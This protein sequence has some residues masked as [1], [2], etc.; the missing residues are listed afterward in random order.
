MQNFGAG[1]PKRF[2]HPRG[3]GIPTSVADFGKHASLLF[4]GLVCG[5]RRRGV[6]HL[7]IGGPYGSKA[8]ALACVTWHGAQGEGQTVFPRIASQPAKYTL[9][10]L[11]IY[12]DALHF[13]N[14]LA[15]QMKEVAKKLSEDEMRAVAAYLSTLN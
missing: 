10:Q 8:G 14:P 2:R 9:D 6:E 7:I 3:D 11:H 15:I 12:R 13:K 4:N 1:L 5:G